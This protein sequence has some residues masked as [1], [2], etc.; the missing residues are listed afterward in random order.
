M[1]EGYLWYDGRRSGL[2]VELLSEFL[3]AVQRVQENPLLYPAV[4]G[5]IHRALLRR[6]PYGVFYEFTDA[7]VTVLAFF[8]GKRQPMSWKAKRDG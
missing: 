3:G 2:G 6:F 8:H 7:E 1:D 4:D 5:H